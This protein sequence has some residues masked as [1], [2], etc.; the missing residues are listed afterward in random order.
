VGLVLLS[1]FTQLS[2]KYFVVKS[3]VKLINMLNRQLFALHVK[4]PAQNM[5]KAIAPSVCAVVFFSYMLASATASADEQDPLNFIVG[6]SRMHDDNLFRSAKN[7]Q[8]EDITAAYAGIRLDK[9]YAQQRFLFDFTLTANKYQKFDVLDYNSKNYKA[10]W[11]WTLTPFLTG[12]ISLDRRQTLNSFQDFNPSTGFKNIRNI[13]VNE[14]QHFEADFSPHN[15]WHLLGGFTRS[16]SQNSNNSSSFVGQDSF[17]SNSADAGVRYNFRSGSSVTAMGH[18]RKGEYT[19][20]QFVAGN[21]FDNAYNEQEV[22][23]KLDWILSG[24]SR[25]NARVAYL[26]R[27]HDHLSNWDYS[28]MVGNVDF[29]WSPTGKMKLILSAASDLSSYQTGDSSYSRLTSFSVKPLYAVS[30]KITMNA[31]AMISKRSFLGNGVI[32]DTNREDWTKSAGV[33]VDWAP[34]RS[35]SVGADIDRTSRDSNSTI[36]D[37]DYTDTS[38]SV[39]ANLFF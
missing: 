16:T 24:K 37:Y 21:A 28:G 22:E 29:S 19:D 25:V 26:S 39:N 14:T 36:P 1:K 30:S 4:H 17:V 31:H 6:V 33:G 32:T 18:V 34:L 7:E 8:S 2:D 35:F 12:T 3:E 11:L 20:R 27:D 38:A 10:A 23:T 13:S 5:I 9:Q 15:V